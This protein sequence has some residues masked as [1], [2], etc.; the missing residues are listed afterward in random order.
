MA[1]RKQVENEQDPETTDILDVPD[2]NVVEKK[3]KR[4]AKK[5]KTDAE[6]PEG[7]QEQPQTQPD[8]KSNKT[9]FLASSYL[10]QWKYEKDSW[11]FQKV[12]QVW[13]LRNMWFSK[14]VLPLLSFNLIID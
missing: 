1:K 5:E 10:Q 3:K 6:N 12:R 2:N 14:M 11:K 7:E 13:I 9:K 4:K 8:Q